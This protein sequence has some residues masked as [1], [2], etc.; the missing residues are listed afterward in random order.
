MKTIT[1]EVDNGIATMYLDRP[2]KLNAMNPTMFEELG[3]AADYIRDDSAV[4]VAIVT[5]RG[6]AFSAGID[7]NSLQE[8][9]VVDLQAFRAVVRKIQRNF[10]AYELIEK[11]IIAM[12]NGHALGA[13][14]ELALAC[15]MIL[16]STEATFGLLEVNIGLV[17]D[18][19]GT[20]RLQRYIGVHRAKELILT[21]K[22]IDAAEADRI[23]LVNAVYTPEELE[24]KTL[25]LANHLM[26]LSPVAVGLCKIAIDRGKGSSIESGLE[27]DA[28][29]QSLAFGYLMEQLKK[30]TD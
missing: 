21:G 30:Q 2:E 12:V 4:K 23:G 15:D 25:E 26:G 1:I 29:S 7:L 9:N 19:G 14:T 5:G 27:Y 17:V 20:Q 6:R 18:L 3:V 11:P 8:Y 28:Q 22:K 24:S 10:R 16:T 13:G